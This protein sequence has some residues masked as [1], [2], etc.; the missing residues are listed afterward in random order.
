MLTCKMEGV[1]NEAR[2]TIP[3]VNVEDLIWD[4]PY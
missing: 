1:S 3:V 2:D 4:W